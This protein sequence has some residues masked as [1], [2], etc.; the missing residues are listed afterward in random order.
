M[1]ISSYLHAQAEL[2]VSEIRMGGQDQSQ[3]GLEPFSRSGAREH[4]LRACLG[5]PLSPIPLP[6]A[7]N[8][9]AT[10]S[11]KIRQHT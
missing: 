2:R 8:S 10:N 1:E 11:G 5:S 6:N 3:S 9:R 4:A 7:D